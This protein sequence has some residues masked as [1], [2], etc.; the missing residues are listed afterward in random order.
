MRNRREWQLEDKAMYIIARKFSGDA[1]EL[2]RTRFD[3]FIG[4]FEKTIR[5]QNWT[6]EEMIR[7]L[8]LKLIDESSD[9]FDSFELAQPIEAK[10][11]EK[12]KEYL[13]SRFHGLET[14]EEFRKEFGK[15][16]QK[17]REGVQDY[18][19]QLEKLFR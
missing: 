6:E 12:V 7:K 16:D 15:C 10:S 11:Y 8:R 4:E 3:K 19:A 5:K 17:P 2:K 14:E 13:Q 9:A 1:D 18:A